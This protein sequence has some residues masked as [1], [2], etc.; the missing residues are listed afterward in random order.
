VIDFNSTKG[1][2]IDHGSGWKRLAPHA[3]VL[4]PPGGKVRLGE[5]STL[6]VYPAPAPPPPPLPPP[7]PVEP[8]KPTSYLS[9]TIQK[10]QEAAETTAEAGGEEEEVDGEAMDGDEP[11]PA[12]AADEIKLSN[13]DFR[14]ALL[15][16]LGRGE[17]AGDGKKGKGKKRKGDGADSEDSD[18][19]PE[20]PLV[21]DKS[22]A[23]ESLAGGLVLRKE[24]AKVKEKA[25]KKE[26]IMKIKF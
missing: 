20:P 23:M 15:P 10:H 25:K 18:A 19:E 21:L 11:E 9:A 17:S 1:T 3:P 12:S 4:L 6:I 22:S 2:F 5:C 8:P 7:P 13:S 26:K 16:F 24:K 14:N